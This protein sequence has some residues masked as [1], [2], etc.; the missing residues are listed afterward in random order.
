[1]KPN[2]EERDE[3]RFPR[4]YQMDAT[5]RRFSKGVAIFLFGFV[6]VPI[7]HLTGILEPP[8]SRLAVALV[9]FPFAALLVWMWFFVDRRVTL[10]ENAIEVAGWP[11]TRKLTREEIL[12]RRMGKLPLR[13]GGGSYYIIVPLDRSKRELKLPPFLHMDELFF[14]W[15]KTLP[16]V[17]Q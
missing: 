16:R 4:T 6:V 12:G 9:A 5:A 1:M 3:K 7:F 2:R 15:M 8:R 13:A 11:S 10:Y 17:K 14:S